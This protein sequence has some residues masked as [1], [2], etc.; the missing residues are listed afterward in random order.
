MGIKKTAAKPAAKKTAAKKTAAKATGRKP[1]A[2]APAKR[3]PAKKTAAKPIARKT[4]GKGKKPAIA[5]KMPTSRQK[6]T[7]YGNKYSIPKEVRAARAGSIIEAIYTAIKRRKGTALGSAIVDTVADNPKVTK[8]K[9]GDVY[10]T[11]EV[12]TTINWLVK[13]A[14]LEIK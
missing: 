3:A 11:S 10:T 8:P 12:I 1:A 9:S 14:R 5:K 13:E 7:V 2:K 4:A 6:S